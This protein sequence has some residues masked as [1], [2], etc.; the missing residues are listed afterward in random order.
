MGDLCMTEEC[1]WS[2]G[3]CE[4]DT[5]CI[6]GSACSNVYHFGWLSLVGSSIYEISHDDFC[7]EE[8]WQTVL[9]VTGYDPDD[10]HWKRLQYWDPPRNCTRLLQVVDFN[11]DQWFNFREAVVATLYLI[12][13]EIDFVCFKS[14]VLIYICAP[15]TSR[16]S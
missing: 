6:A 13:G 1:A 4:T 14:K 12:E 5:A 10:S 16:E 11:Q 3:S 7:T 2:L 8:T 9:L 15:I